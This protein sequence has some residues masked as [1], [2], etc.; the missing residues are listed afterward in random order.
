MPITRIAIVED[1]SLLAE[2]VGLALRGEGLDVVVAD[3]SDEQG[4]L[5]SLAADA[6]LLVML[7]LD[8]GEP[9]RDGATLI[10]ALRAAGAHVLVVSGS[11]EIVRVAAAVEAGAIGHVGKEQPFEVLLAT[12]LRAVAGEPVLSSFERQ[13]LLAQLRRHR[14]EESRR[15][16]PFRALTPKESQ[17]LDELSNGKSVDRIAHD[18]VVS[19]ATVRT[20]V[21]GVLT[22]LDVRSQLAAVAKARSA[23]WRA[24]NSRDG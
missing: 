21:R 18:W 10:P 16:A 2:S 8:L 22:K 20:Q 5:A 19:E 13:E 14:V 6:S 24:R 3:L 9:I 15:L 1:H 4:V 17:V 12:V 7:D 11:R 23:G